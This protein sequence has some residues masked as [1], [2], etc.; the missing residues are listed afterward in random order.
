MSAAPELLERVSEATRKHYKQ[1]VHM[2]QVVAERVREIEATASDIP[3][4]W[5]GWFRDMDAIFPGGFTPEGFAR[6]QEEFER[7]VKRAYRLTLWERSG[8]ADGVR[9]PQ[10][11]EEWSKLPDIRQEF[12]RRRKGK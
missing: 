3:E 9:I 5:E 11:E 10:T 1:F 4:A 7:L 6:K 8:N 12:E 2:L